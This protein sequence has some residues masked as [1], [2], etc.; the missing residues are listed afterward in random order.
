MAGPNATLERFSTFHGSPRRLPMGEVY[1][2]GVRDRG[3]AT[4][5]APHL[6]AGAVAADEPLLAGVATV[7]ITPE[8]GRML[9]GYSNRTHGATGTLDPL[10]AK[11]VVLRPANTSVAIVTLDLGRTPEEAVLA[12]VRERTGAEC[13]VRTCS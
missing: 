10:M 4:L 1:H 7:D 11:A 8:P 2:G 13:G 12:K 3:C 9:W 6:L 5:V